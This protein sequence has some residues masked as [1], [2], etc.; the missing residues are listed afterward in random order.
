MS[1]LK[2]CPCGHSKYGAQGFPNRWRWQDPIDAYAIAANFCLDC[3]AHLLPN[4]D[5][6][7]RGKVVGEATLR[8]PRNPK[9]YPAQEYTERKPMIGKIV[10]KMMPG[11]KSCVL[12]VRAEEPKP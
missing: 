10:I 12:L 5:I 2:T 11:E 9:R 1:E 8:S 3:G 4:G 6:E 7:R